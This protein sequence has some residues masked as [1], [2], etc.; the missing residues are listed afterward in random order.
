MCVH[1]LVRMPH[2]CAVL[3]H[4]RAVSTGPSCQAPVA[5]CCLQDVLLTPKIAAVAAS[6]EA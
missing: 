6:S 4:W 1:T 5:R 2:A 3:Q